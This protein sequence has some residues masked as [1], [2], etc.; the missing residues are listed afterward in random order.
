MKNIKLFAVLFII[1]VS[2]SFTACSSNNKDNES[3][4][5]S[6]ETTTIEQ[7]ESTESN[8]E[9]E[10]DKSAQIELVTV[11]PTTRER[12]AVQ[13]LVKLGTLKGPT[14]ISMVQ[15]MLKE[16]EET[17]INV[18]DFTVASTPDELV[19][20]LTNGEIDVAA[21]PTN[22]AAMLYNKTNG[23]IKIGAI[24]TLGMLYIM[25]NGNTINSIKDLSGKTIY[26]TGKGAVPEYILNYVISKNNI[27]DTTIEYKPEHAELAALMASDKAQIGMLPEPF[28]TNVK[29]NNDK[30]RIAIDL[31]KEFD[32]I[33][34]PAD[35]EYSLPM[36][37]IV[38]R[39]EFLE[40]HAQAFEIFLEEY[41]ESVEYT[42]ND[43]SGAAQLVEKYGIMPKAEIAEK[44]IPN[45]N[46]VFLTGENMKNSINNF[47]KILNEINPSSIG[48]N[49][50]D[51]EFYYLQK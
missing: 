26:A 8:S 48:G 36:G 27:N 15:L 32:K 12:P 28:V 5:E 24:N 10:N 21:I 45:C 30:T 40:K 2:I 19:A 51:D 25:E 3:T 22:T 38:V 4:T 43:I 37:C 47:Y 1:L 23:N 9:D 13:T 29:M 33:V 7:N 6:T 39:N 46:I 42:N 50:P 44:A 41:K 18:Y 16:E 11:E 14:G 31:N 35:G 34:N 49:I 17:D 20:K